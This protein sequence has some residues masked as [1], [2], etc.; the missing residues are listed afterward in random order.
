[1]ASFLVQAVLCLC[2]ASHAAAAPADQASPLPAAAAFDGPLDLTHPLSKAAQNW[3]GARGFNFTLQVAQEFP[4]FGGFVAFNEFCM[5]EHLGTHLDA[6]YHFNQAGWKVHEIPVSRLVAPGVLLDASAEAAAN[7]D[8]F[9]GVE[10]LEAWEARHGRVA[11]GSVVLVRFGWANKYADR[12][13]YFGVATDDRT[14]NDTEHL[15]F[16][17]LSAELA[18]TLAARKVAGVGVDTPSVDPGKAGDHA[19]LAHRALAA[20]NAFN[21]ENVNLATTLLPPTGFTL[22]VMPTLIVGGTGA[23][24]RIVALP[25]K[26]ALAA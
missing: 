21:L 3:P 4:E 26:G 22:L 17:S 2:A 15:S 18:R 7:R 12:K 23:P 6:P 1:M 9:L 20:A 8:L 14:S 24:V 25:G 5:A 16:P 11:E 10:A 13:D 19:P